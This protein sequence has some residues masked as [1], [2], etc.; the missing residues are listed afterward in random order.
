MREYIIGERRCGFTA[1]PRDHKGYTDGDKDV[2]LF[3]AQMETEAAGAKGLP[4]RI[5]EGYDL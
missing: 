5:Y 2:D 1:L 3:A 4:D